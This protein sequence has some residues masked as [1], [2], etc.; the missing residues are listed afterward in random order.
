MDKLILNEKLDELKES[1]VKMEALIETLTKNADEQMIVHNQLMN[2]TDA[3]DNIFSEYEMSVLKNNEKELWRKLFMLDRT[4][5]EILKAIL[6][7][8]PDGEKVLWR[9]KMKE[10]HP[11][12]IGRFDKVCEFMEEL[13]DSAQ[14]VFLEMFE[15]RSTNNNTQ[16]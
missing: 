1:T 14:E 8:F 16:D 4:V 9:T 6:A 11:G 10:R 12:V 15:N 13:R 3:V 2:T 7:Q 5:D